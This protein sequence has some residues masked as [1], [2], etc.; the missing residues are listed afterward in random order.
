[1]DKKCLLGLVAILTLLLTAC[2]DDTD[3]MVPSVDRHEPVSNESAE[4]TD[5]TQSEDD[6]TLTES[7]EES[8]MMNREEDSL[9]ENAE[10]ER[11]ESDSV[12]ITIS[13]AGDVTLGNYFGQDYSWSFLESWDKNQ[14]ADY[15]FENVYDIFNQD[16]MTLVNLEG[17]LTTAEERREEQTYCIKGDPACAKILTAGSVEAVGMANNHCMDYFKPGVADTV[18]AVKEE[19]IVY[20]YDSVTGIY[21]TK[22]IKIGYVSVNVIGYG[23]GV[24]KQLESGIEDL[25]NQD[26]DLILTSCHW[27]IERENF[28]D[29]YQ[30]KLGKKCIDWG[31]DLV[32][33]HHPHVIQGVEEYQGKYI[34]YSLGNFCFGA[35]RNPADKDCIIFQQTFQFEDGERLAETSARVIPCS[36][37]SVKTRNDYKP[38]PAKGDEWMR[39]LDRMRTYSEPFHV[40]FDDDGVIK[41]KH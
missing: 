29:D 24:G 27:G 33:G 34:V 6:L 21:E 35:N 19:G 14:D 1:M 13:A 31:A 9:G 8:G 28:P 26:V 37:S 32:I 38:T 36:V 15:Y 12:Q 5:D 23:A 11:A 39:I 10:A 4:N 41:Q 18:E 22:G 20:A 25:K 7:P 16:D 17:P 40:E 2:G 30:Q 3:I